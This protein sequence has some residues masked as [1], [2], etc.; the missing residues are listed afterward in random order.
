MEVIVTDYDPRW[1]KLF[2]QDAEEL[3]Q[4][5]GLLLVSLEHIGSTSVPDLAAKPIIDIQAIVRQVSSVALVRPSL[6]L[7]GWEQGSFAPDP[8]W[9]LYFRKHTPDGERTH[10]LHVYEADYP[11]AAA[12]QL[13]RDYLR[14]HDDEAQ[15]YAALK[16]SLAVRFRSD[17]LAYNDAKT[18]YIES[19]LA[20]AREQNG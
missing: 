19:I 14:A 9:H 15:R 20:R 4:A 1:P 7:L 10:H 13:F 12:H 6:A 16:R 5:F 11:A 18:E 2:Q 3:R 17:S 8:D